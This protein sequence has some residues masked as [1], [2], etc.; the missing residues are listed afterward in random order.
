MKNRALLFFLFILSAFGA[1]SYKQ[2][3]HRFDYDQKAPLDIQQGDVKD[4]DGVRFYDLSYASPKGGRVPAYLVVPKASGPFAAI[5]WG[6]WY[7]PGSPQRNRTEFL[8]EAIVLGQA[9]VVSILT[10]GPIAPPI[11]YCLAKMSIPNASPM[12]GIAI[13]RRWEPCLA[14]ST[15]DSKSLS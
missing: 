5:V 12:S 8:E 6:H 4:R 2:L 15:S 7:M 11:C 3:V 14:E 1:E 10:D 9:G 13:M